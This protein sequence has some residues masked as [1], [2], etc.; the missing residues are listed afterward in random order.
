[1]ETSQGKIL[2]VD[3]IKN[4]LYIYRMFLE[5]E[6][7]GVETASNLKSTFQ[8]LSLD[9]YTV[10]ISEYLPPFEET[11]HMLHE[12]KEHSPETYI[13]IVTN[14]IVDEK[15]YERLFDAGVDDLIL[16]PYSPNKI[17]VHVKKGF[18]NR[19]LIIEKRKLEG[20][21]LV[22]PIARQVE[23]PVYNLTHFQRCLRQELK[24]A[25][26][27]GH[28]LSLVLM[29]VPHEAITRNQPEG[30]TADLLR[31]LRNNTRE[32][33]VVGRGNGGFGL[34][35][36]ETDEAG[37]KALV[38]RLIYLIQNHTPFQIEESLKSTVNLVSFQTFTFP[39][40]FMIPAP[41]SSI[42][43]DFSRQFPHS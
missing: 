1:M 7:Y 10:L 40:K 41:L 34:L 13:I 4:L 11:F 25:K 3:P 24:K 39:E 22:D 26:R 30:L 12:V 36:P 37:S 16:K 6:R 15:T 29:D 28:S 38:K 14:A 8:K 5:K 31:I 19:K 20:E 27:H 23:L 2:I 42:V 32:E 43:E 17:L 18:R 9:R 35:L 21:S 33:D